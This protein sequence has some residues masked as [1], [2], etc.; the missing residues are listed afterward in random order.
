[1]GY[2]QQD[3]SLNVGFDANHD[4][5]ENIFYFAEGDWYQTAFKGALLIRPVVGRNMI[6]GTNRQKANPVS[7]VTFPNPVQNRLQFAGIR[8]TGQIPATV[9]VYDLFGRTVL[10]QKLYRNILNTASL[11]NGMYLVRMQS[12]TAVYTA[13]FIVKH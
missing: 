6:L 8:I 13:K 5:S 1:V 7:V 11:R 10:K 4:A 9:V 2:R 3:Q 12:G